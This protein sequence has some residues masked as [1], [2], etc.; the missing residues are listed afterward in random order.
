MIPKLLAFSQVHH[1]SACRPTLNVLFPLPRMPLPTLPSEYF[2]V[3]QGPI[4]HPLPRET[5]RDSLQAKPAP[6][7][8]KPGRVAHSLLSSECGALCTR[9]LIEFP[10]EP[11]EDRNK[12]SQLRDEETETQ[13]GQVTDSLKES[14]TRQGTESGFEAMTSRSLARPIMLS[15]Y[16]GFV[17]FYFMTFSIEAHTYLIYE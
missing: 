6:L 16:L 5:S 3:L 10:P 7:L 13:R 17:N 14:Q 15:I 4:N 2:S 12:Q 8:K 1:S 11:S 9:G